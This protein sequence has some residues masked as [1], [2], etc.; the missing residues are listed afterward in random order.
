MVSEV[1]IRVIPPPPAVPPS[2]TLPTPLL[3]SDTV[4][5]TPGSMLTHDISIT[6]ADTVLGA[7]L[8]SVAPLPDGASL[9]GVQITGARHG[10]LQFGCSL[11]TKHT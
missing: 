10:V 9:S 3:P 4:Y 2:F 11:Y 7:T 8:L 5:I 1:L 6:T